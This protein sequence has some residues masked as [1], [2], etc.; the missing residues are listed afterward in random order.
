MKNVALVIVSLIVC[1][2]SFAQQNTILGEREGAQLR[3]ERMLN[4]GQV[5][6][7]FD[8]NE[9]INQVSG[10][11]GRKGFNT[12]EFLIDTSVTIVPAERDQRYPAVSYDGDNYLVVWQTDQEQAQN[13]VSDC[14]IYATR[15]SASGRVLDPQGIIVSEVPIEECAPRVAF[16]GTNYLVVW[17]D[18]QN[19]VCAVYAK[20]IST[21]GTVLDTVAISVSPPGARHWGPDVTFDGTHF[22]VVWYEYRWGVWYNILASRVNSA[23]QVLDPQP[24]SIA[25][26]LCVG[27]VPAVNSDGSATFVVWVNAV[28]GDLAEI[29]GARIDTSGVVIDTVPIA[30]CHS[31]YAQSRPSLAFGKDR[32]LVAWQEYAYSANDNNIYAARITRT[33]VALDSQPIRVAEQYSDQN[34]PSVSFDGRNWLVAWQEWESEE[35]HGIRGARVSHD[36]LVLDAEGIDLATTGMGQ[37]KPAV[38][39][40]GSNYHVVWFQLRTDPPYFDVYGTRVSPTGVVLDTA[41]VLISTMISP[42]KVPAVAYDGTNYFVV[43]QDHR[44]TY[45]WDIY[46]ARVSPAGVSLDPAGIPVCQSDSDQV[47]PG[48]AFDGRN[49][50]VVWVDYRGG[51]NYPNIYGARVDRSGSVLDTNIIAVAVGRWAHQE[52]AVDFDGTNYIVVWKADGPHIYGCRVSVDGRVVDTAYIDISH[53]VADKWYPSVRS[54]NQNSLVVWGEGSD[55]YGTRV[56]RAGVVVDTQGIPIRRDPQLQRFNAIAYDGR[57][58]L[59]VWQDYRSGN[60]ADIYAARLTP[61]GVVLDTAGVLL[62]YDANHQTYPEVV[63]DGRDFLAFWVDFRS[64]YYPDLC[65]ARV[66]RSCVVLDTFTVCSQAKGQRAPAAA[67]GRGSQVLLTYSGW[68]DSINHKPANTM[69]IWGKLLPEVMIGEEARGETAGTRFGLRVYPTPALNK[70]V[71][72][73]YVVARS[74]KVKLAIYNA[75]GQVQE[76]LVDGVVDAGTYWLGVRRR[77]GAGVYFVSLTIEDRMITKKVVLL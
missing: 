3:S 2:L 65:G 72:I 24:I 44:D 23:G 48:V 67:R 14:D 16:D 58:Y 34:M 4:T 32:Y 45:D 77:L 42:Q 30:I 35:R 10:S 29:C 52:V 36:G 28:M 27:G 71:R 7:P 63:Y 33:G 59:V 19:W 18:F 64:G 51:P 62:S 73:Q 9:V 49:F 46:G 41:G 26:D 11:A 13:P 43:W 53:T 76:V 15:V 40:D 25:K 69:R 8:V 17:Y 20:R 74:G 38:S 50:L 39:F 22:L 60:N 6:P 61:R 68:T 66:D 55:I 57:N 54:G 47:S 12:G 70:K 21:A 1:T 31:G 5:K 37:M 56:D 75:L